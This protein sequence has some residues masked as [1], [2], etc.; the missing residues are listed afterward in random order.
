LLWEGAL[1]E[2][3]GAQKQAEIDQDDPVFDPDA[4]TSFEIKVCFFLRVYFLSK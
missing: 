2:I 4:E 1:A 3:F